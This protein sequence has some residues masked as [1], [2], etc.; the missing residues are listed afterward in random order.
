MTLLPG[1]Y[2]ETAWLMCNVGILAPVL[3]ALSRSEVNS[4]SPV[5]IPADGRKLFSASHG[6]REELT[7]LFLLFVT[8]YR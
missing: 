8:A 2:A 7:K 6:I 3:P 1:A 5:G 4:T